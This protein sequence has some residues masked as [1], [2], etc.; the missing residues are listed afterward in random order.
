[1]TPQSYW[2]LM[3]YLKSPFRRKQYEGAMDVQ[4]IEWA[5][6]WLANHPDVKANP[7]SLMWLDRLRANLK[8]Y[9]RECVAKLKQG[10]GG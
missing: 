4:A 5:V 3:K 2:G 6:H 7:N 8:H 9:E 10:E 1:M